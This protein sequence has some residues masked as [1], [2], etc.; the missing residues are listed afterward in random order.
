MFNTIKEFTTESGLTLKVV[1][2]SVPSSPRHD[3]NLGT[4]VCFHNR[5]ILGDVND[6]DLNDYSGWKEMEQAIIKN[7][8]PAILLPL[9]L[10]DHSGITIYHTPFSCRWDSV[11][12]GFLFVSKETLRK[13]YS[14]KRITKKV[15][16]TAM[17]VLLGELETYDQYIRGYVY[18]FVLEDAEGD[19]IDSCWGFYGDDVTK[20]GILDNINDEELKS[21]ILEEEFV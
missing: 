17:Q 21:L 7:E 8:N 10:Y 1:V 6:Y 2:D 3:D 5:Y 11:Q 12:V 13:E 16:E 20:N 4:M 9:Y 14:V 18:G 15:K 19:E